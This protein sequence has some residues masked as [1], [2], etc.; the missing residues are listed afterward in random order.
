MEGWYDAGVQHRMHTASGYSSPY[1]GFGN[2]VIG[3]N[4]RLACLMGKLGHTTH[5]LSLTLYSRL[6]LSS[7]RQKTQGK[8]KKKRGEFVCEHIAREPVARRTLHM[9]MEMEKMELTEL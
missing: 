8:K 4:C 2:E 5:S 6:V 7:D 9:Q 1:S 3:L